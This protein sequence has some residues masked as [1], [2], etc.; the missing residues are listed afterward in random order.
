[1]SWHHAAIVLDDQV[2]LCPSEKKTVEVLRDHVERVNKLWEPAGFMMSHDEIRA[3][4]Q[5]AAC[6]ARSLSAGQLL[7][8]NARTCTKIIHDVNPSARI[9]VW[10]DMFDPHHNAKDH[11]Y[12]AR[13]DYAGSWEGLDKDVTIVPWYFEKRAESLKFFADRGHRQVIAGYYD[14]NPA[15]VKDWLK[16]AAPYEG[17]EAV[18]YTTWQNNYRDLET[19][20]KL[21]RGAEK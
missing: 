16:A 11:F 5:C 10:S 7:A 21:A 14:S 17:V 15:G 2:C 13:G 6:R 9:Y 3:W 1:V 8:D 19:F 4:N 20:F 12:L 18:M